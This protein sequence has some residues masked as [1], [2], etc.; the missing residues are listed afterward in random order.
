[1]LIHN[2]ARHRFGLSFPFMVGALQDPPGRKLA[3]KGG[4]DALSNLLISMRDETPGSH[5]VR[6][7][8][9][10]RLRQPVAAPIHSAFRLPD[11]VGI[12]SLQANRTSLFVSPEYLADDGDSIEA[13]IASIWRLNGDAITEGRYSFRAGRFDVFDATDHQFAAEAFALLDDP[14]DV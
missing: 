9:C 2:N 11:Q 8:E 7:S 14:D 1:L 6:V 12:Q 4:R 13:V 3:P 10:D 5:L